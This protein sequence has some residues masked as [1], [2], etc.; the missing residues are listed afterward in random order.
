MVRRRRAAHCDDPPRGAPRL[1]V[2]TDADVGLSRSLPMA[3]LALGGGRD[4]E[5]ELTPLPRSTFH[6]EMPAVCVYNAANNC[7]SEADT[8]LATTP[9]LLPVAIEYMRQIIGRNPDAGI[10]H[11]EA[12]AAQV[13]FGAKRD[14]AARM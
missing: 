14:A 5:A 9:T 10:L 8:S 11:R 3:F 4:R 2:N 13:L 1:S 12:D 6:G 7:E